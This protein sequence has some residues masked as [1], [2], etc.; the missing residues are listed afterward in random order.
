MTEAKG[1]EDLT[2]K[3]SDQLAVNLRQLKLPNLAMVELRSSAPVQVEQRLV[4]AT[5]GDYSSGPAVPDAATVIS[6]SL[7]DSGDAAG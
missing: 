3:P 5:A 1:F 7:S 4:D 6:L 2:V